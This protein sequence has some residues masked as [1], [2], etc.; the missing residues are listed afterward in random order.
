MTEQLSKSFK[1]LKTSDF[2]LTEEEIAECREAFAM[3]DKNGDGS[4][5][6]DELGKTLKSLGQKPT[7]QDLK[8]MIAGQYVCNLVVLVLFSK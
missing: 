2:D 4:I 6:T 8:D 5:T 3:F 7:A 1:K